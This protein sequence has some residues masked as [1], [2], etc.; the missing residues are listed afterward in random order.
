M[1]DI[2]LN[3]YNNLIKELPE[4]LKTEFKQSMSYNYP[5]P[6]DG[7][8]RVNYGYSYKKV[9]FE[10]CYQMVGGQNIPVYPSDAQKSGRTYEVRIFTDIVYWVQYTRIIDGAWVTDKKTK[11]TYEN[12]VLGSMP[13]MIKSNLCHLHGM[14]Q[15][16][17]IRIGEDPLDIG[18]YVRIGGSDKCN[19]A[20][21]NNSKNYPQYHVLKNH[22]DNIKIKCDFTSKPGDNYEKSTYI[23]TAF[24]DENAIYFM[25]TL[26]KELTLYVPFFVIFY[27]FGMTTDRDIME[28]IMPDMDPNSIAN[29]A[30]EQIINSALT[31]DYSN[32]K[33][34]GIKKEF[35]NN[36]R[37][38]DL[39]D[40]NRRPKK[41]ISE[42]LMLLAVNINENDG[43]AQ[44]E[45]YV[46]NSK[47]EKQNMA[48]RHRIAQRLDQSILPHIGTSPD[49]RPEKLKFIGMLI[50]N[51]CVI[52][53]KNMPPTDRNKY[54]HQV[55]NAIGPGIIAALKAIVNIVNINPMNKALTNSIKANPYVKFEDVWKNTHKPN[56]IGDNLDKALKSGSNDVITINRS[57][58]IKSRTV[59]V[60]KEVV[61]LVSIV[62]CINGATP[63]PN[64]IGG[65]NGDSNLDARKVI[66]SQQGILCDVQGVEGEKAGQAGQFTLGC[67]LTTIIDTKSIEQMIA[68]KLQ[69]TSMAYKDRS[70]GIVYVNY[71]AIGSHPNNHALREE[72]VAL[73]RKGII[74]RKTGI[75]LS[76]LES[77]KLVF[78]TAQGRFA[79][80]YLIVY[81]NYA[82]RIKNRN[83]A[84]KQYIKY[85]VEHA[86]KLAS[87]EMSFADLESE[88][89]IE[90]LTAPENNNIYCCDSYPTFLKNETNPLQVYT[91][92]CIPEMEYCINT[93][94]CPYGNHSDTVRT[95]YES[96]LVKQTVG[97]PV[98]NHNNMYYSKCPIAYNTYVPIVSTIADRMLLPSGAPVNVMNLAIGSNQEDSFGVRTRTSQ[99]GKFGV[100]MITMVSIE[101]D[102]DQHLGLPV[103]GK[104][105]NIRGTSYSHIG[106]DGFPKIGTVVKKGMVLISIKK[107]NSDG[108]EID[109]SV[110]HKKTIKMRVCGYSSDCN[111]NGAKVVKVRLSS[112]RPLKEGDK[113]AH[114]SGNKGILSK[115]KWDEQFPICKDGSIPDLIF[116][117]H[118]LPSRMTINQPTEGHEAEKALR[119]GIRIDG[120][121]FRNSSVKYLEDPDSEIGYT[122]CY[123]PITGIEMRGKVFNG[124]AFYQRLTRMVMDN[125]NAVN[126][127]IIDIR[128]G[129]SNKGI[130]GGGGLRLGEMEVNTVWANSAMAMLYE[131]MYKKGDGKDV[132]ICENCKRIAIVN[133]NIGSEIYECRTCDNPVFVTISTCIATIAFC[134]YMEQMGISVEFNT[135]YPRFEEF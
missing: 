45:S 130:A 7:I 60:L 46:I 128:T 106:A 70:Y 92:L 11:I 134:R 79:R 57:T 132:I 40:S 102:S 62:Y 31:I 121:M 76:P 89:I 107:T 61:N 78:F 44:S 23:V 129:Q 37:F 113:M 53:I 109:E 91:H 39:Y 112:D 96:K 47:D 55:C 63:D 65:K 64:G 38:A 69:P 66:A 111:K 117:P 126:T 51:C 50:K 56:A 33:K 29:Q 52:R 120:T 9:R 122:T 36:Y 80:P 30:I 34:C 104:T 103:Q 1:A 98:G 86:Q 19:V 74:D 82:D 28:T 116:S 123:N 77:N 5:A 4:V 68:K 135:E 16:D 84:F 18:G 105:I 94:A 22:K 58:E 12:K 17:I 42:L 124:H 73:R 90:Y 133:T 127:P 26:G 125:Y 25:L 114:R 85:T 24:T 71:K 35:I 72:F 83:V 10:K 108:T 75:A 2:Q 97:L 93:L 87:G 119:K 15:Q 8:V 32:H 14:T 110:L 48:V 49:D 27:I 43:G 131:K 3:S 88:G 100:S 95:T 20:F 118:S 13:C 59:T 21:K 6:V 41:N 115:I 101:L 99:S 81:S 67:C 54:D